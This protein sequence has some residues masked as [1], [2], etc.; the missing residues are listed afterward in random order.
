MSILTHTMYAGNN[1]PS[2]PR[3]QILQPPSRISCRSAASRNLETVDI[4]INIIIIIQSFPL[5]IGVEDYSPA[6]IG[7]IGTAYWP[8]CVST[9]GRSHYQAAP[10][11]HQQSAELGMGAMESMCGRLQRRL[12][13]NSVERKLL[14]DTCVYFFNYRTRTAGLNQIKTVYDPLVHG[15]TCILNYKLSHYYEV[16]NNTV[17]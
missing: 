9:Q 13:A 15:D 2:R 11:Q 12:T 17:Y 16:Q 5:S 7:R 6:E 1:N 14:L 8:S 10:P 3:S 4:I